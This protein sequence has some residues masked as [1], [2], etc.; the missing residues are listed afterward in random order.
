MSN[1][2]LVPND[3]DLVENEIEEAN[4][5]VNSLSRFVLFRD[6]L[7]MLMNNKF[8]SRAHAPHLRRFGIRTVLGGCSFHSS[9]SPIPIPQVRTIW[10]SMSSDSTIVLGS[11]SP[12][13][14][15]LPKSISLNDQSTP[16]PPR[17]SVLL[18]RLSGCALRGPGLR[19][20]LRR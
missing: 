11:P 14:S 16:Y 4:L 18:T 20:M 15:L 7:D 12:T 5:I 6:P 2:I 17:F 8:K 9:S 3:A 1:G 10:C 13:Y 19:R